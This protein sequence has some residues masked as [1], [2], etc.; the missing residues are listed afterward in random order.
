[1]A[2]LSRKSYLIIYINRDI[3]SLVSDISRVLHYTYAGVTR[4]T[5][6]DL[7]KAPLT[8]GELSQGNGRLTIEL[9]RL[10]AGLV[11]SYVVQITRMK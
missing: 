3:R 7:D 6:F 4:N 10:I 2:L 1:M 9:F 5:Y 11:P 8:A